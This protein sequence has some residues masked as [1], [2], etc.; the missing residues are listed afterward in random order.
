MTP[1]R[2]ALAALGLAG[3]AALFTQEAEAADRRKKRRR[4]RQ[5]KRDM[6]RRRR[7]A[8]RRVR[9]GVVV[10]DAMPEAWQPYITAAL[11]DF[12]THLP[13]TAPR[14]IYQRA[15]VGRACHD[16]PRPPEG[17]VICLGEGLPSVTWKRMQGFIKPQPN[18]RV[19]GDP[20]RFLCHELMHVVT[21]IDDNYNSKPGESC[22]WGRESRLAPFD[23]AYLQKV[24]A[25]Q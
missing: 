15:E 9:N 8:R 2:R 5:H 1:S 12:N 18:P 19:H 13:A 7:E 22:V 11:E 20:A 3:I 6:Q 10:H 25:K 17:I 24:F 23:I 14:L 4:R 21:K 16:F